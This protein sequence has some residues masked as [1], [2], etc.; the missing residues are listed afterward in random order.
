MTPK[1]ILM[2]DKLVGKPACALLSVIEAVRRFFSGQRHVSPPKRIVF[3]KLI[4][5]GSTVLACPAFKEA[6]KLVGKNNMFFLAFEQ[7]R[8]IV[9]LLPYFKPEN[10]IT[11]DDSNLPKFISGLWRAMIRM[12]REKIDAAIDMEGLTRSS[13][14]I[15]YLTGARHRVGYYN[16][17]S[18][19]PYRGRLFTHELNYSFQHHISRSFTALVRAL[20]APAS[21]TPMLKEQIK[22][23]KE[24]PQF[25]P[26]DKDKKEVRSILTAQYEKIFDGKIVLLNPN[27]SDLLPLRRW[28]TENFIELGKQILSNFPN[29]AIV[30]TGAPGEREEAEKIAAMIG[31]KPRVFSLA[32]ET[33]MRQLLTLYCLSDLLITND[34]GPC[35]FAA[36]TSINGIALFGPETPTLYSPLSKQIKPITAGLSCS[37]CVN[38]LNHRFSPCIDNKCMQNIPVDEVYGEAAARLGSVI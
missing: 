26:E 23:E 3:V 13:A 27:C 12:R 22:N 28:P 32:G 1:R 9:D 18:E 6:S 36:L 4:E 29:T 7:N 8:P 2:L 33:T 34:S 19:G 21:Q 25:K 30:I 10:I 24:L 38:M 16:F 31:E 15:T 14:I 5:M 20:K 35:H 17:T 11:I 37:P